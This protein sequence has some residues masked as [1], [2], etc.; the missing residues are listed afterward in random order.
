MVV[1]HTYSVKSDENK[2]DSDDGSDDGH[3]DD[4]STVSFASISYDDGWMG[5]NVT[6]M[7]VFHS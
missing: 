4:D 3:G 7:H 5:K 1:N 6:S 2:D